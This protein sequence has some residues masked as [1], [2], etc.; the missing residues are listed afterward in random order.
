MAELSVAIQQ[1]KILHWYL[2]DMN[3][4]KAVEFINQTLQQQKI[5]HLSFLPVQFYYNS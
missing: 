4:P 5:K 2:P 1:R 3:L